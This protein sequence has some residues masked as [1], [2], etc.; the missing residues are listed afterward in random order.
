MVGGFPTAINS[1]GS[2]D[3]DII[4]AEGPQGV[5]TMS[6]AFDLLVGLAKTGTAVPPELIV[7]LS[8]LPASVKK[9]AMA[10]L[11]QSQKPKPADLQAVQIKLDQEL[12]KVQEIASK[13]QLHVAQAQKALAEAGVAGLPDPPD[14]G[15]PGQQVDTAADLAKAELDLAKA[16]QIYGELDRTPEP[17]AI[18]DAQ[19]KVAKAERDRAEAQRKMAETMNIVRH[20]AAEPAMIP[21]PKPP[22]GSNE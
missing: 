16:R 20:G 5:N 8:S 15:G 18:A 9:R 11:I 1:L 17:G 6:D 4:L 14:A 7:E 3:V 19:A 13:A 10:H 12:A 22:G 21:P 2:L